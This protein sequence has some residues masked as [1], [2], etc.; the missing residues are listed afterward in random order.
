MA[1]YLVKVYGPKD[2]E[3]LINFNP[4]YK[5]SPEKKVKTMMARWIANFLRGV[6]VVVN[7]FCP[8]NIPAKN[9]SQ[10]NGGGIAKVMNGKIVEVRDGN[11]KGR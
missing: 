1:I 2:E 3:M 4:Q 7:N 6:K 9:H 5:I 10:R 8:V 11:E